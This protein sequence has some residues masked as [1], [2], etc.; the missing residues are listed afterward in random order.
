MR[1]HGTH[2]SLV[3][4]G[5]TVFAS[6]IAGQ[7]GFNDYRANILIVGPDGRF[8]GNVEEPILGRD[9]KRQTLL[10]K[11]NEQALEPDDALAVGDGANDLAM[12][13][14]A[15]LGVAY[16]AKPAVRAQADA[17]I[18][19][20]DLTALLFLQGYHREEFCR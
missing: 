7:L 4:G 12:I 10:R 14:L 9:A 2:T 20:G 18:E 13:E 1:A 19:H 3:S 8:T 6:R 11:L 15:G 5:F 17:A 16:R